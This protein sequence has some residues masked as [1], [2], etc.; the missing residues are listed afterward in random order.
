MKKRYDTVPGTTSLAPVETLRLKNDEVGSDDLHTCFF[1]QSCL[2]IRD[3]HD[4]E[5]PALTVAQGFF[6]V[7]VDA[8]ANATSVA[9]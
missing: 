7:N 1:V 2:L 3:N 4:R 9:V 6:S 8:N 5:T